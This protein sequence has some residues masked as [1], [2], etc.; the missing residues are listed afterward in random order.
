MM[1]VIIPSAIKLSDIISSVMLSIVFQVSLWRLSLLLVM[2]SSAIKRRMTL[3]VVMLIVVMLK[4]VA[5]PGASTIT[6]P[7]E[8]LKQNGPLFKNP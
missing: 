2:L 7:P 5:P 1:M 3:I 4:V 8:A 6:S